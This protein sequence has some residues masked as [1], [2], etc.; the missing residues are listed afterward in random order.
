LKIVT[1][2]SNTDSIK[3]KVDMVAFEKS[4][5]LIRLQLKAIIARDLW[6]TNEFYQIIDADNES[7]SKAVEI[8]QTP[9]AY[10]KILK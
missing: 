1:G 8:L 5:P 9:G 10:E 4:K 3:T 6:T 7:L 2:S